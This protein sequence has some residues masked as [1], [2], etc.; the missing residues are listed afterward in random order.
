MK[1]LRRIAV[2]MSLTA[3]S[4][5]TS[6]QI[7]DAARGERV[8]R[9]CG[10]CHSLEPNR[11]MTGPSLA[12][13][14]NQGRGPA[15]LP[16]LLGRAQVIRHH[17]DR[18][19]ARR[20]AQGPA[21]LHSGKYDDFP[22]HQE[23]AATRRPAGVSQGC[24]AARTRP[25]CDRAARRADGRHDGDDGRRG[26]SEPEE[27]RSGRSGA[28]DQSLRG[29]LQGHDRGRQDS[30]FLGAEFALQDGCEQRRSAEGRAPRSL[31]PA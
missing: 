17:L 23:C 3:L 30:R 5:P 20:M 21:T 24:N 4:A 11:N 7:G 14:W 18:R 31:P 6:A 1:H 27:A 19:H 2:A 29:H 22:G 9:T 8:Y 15:E 28:V 26:R 10:A 16:A 12:E 25:A 13:V